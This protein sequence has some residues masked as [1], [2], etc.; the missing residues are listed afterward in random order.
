MTV[1]CHPVANCSDRTRVA[2]RV[3]ETRMTWSPQGVL[4]TTRA[5]PLDPPS[6]QARPAAEGSVKTQKTPI[7][8]A[9]CQRVGVT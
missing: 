7:M 1:A 6:T 4:D 3:V 9:K 5:C 2:G 8:P